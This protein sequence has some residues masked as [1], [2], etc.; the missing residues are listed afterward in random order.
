M[1]LSSIRSCMLNLV[2]L[3]F[4]KFIC[5]SSL[6]VRPKV[7]IVIMYSLSGDV[8]FISDTETL[9]L[10]WQKL[11]ID[12]L[13]DPSWPFD[14]TL[15][16]YDVKSDP[17][18]TTKYLLNR[19]H[20]KSMPNVTVIV[21]PETEIL[22]EA[23]GAV[24]AKY[25]IPCIAAV[26]NPNPTR[27][28][29]PW[30]F[31]TSFL[32]EAPASYMFQTLVDTYVSSGVRTLVAVTMH[33]EFDSYN[34][35]TCFGAAALA[36]SRGIKVQAKMSLTAESVSAD[37]VTMVEKIRDSYNPDAI[38][39]CDWASCALPENI[40]QF[41]PMPAFAKADYL[42]KALSLLDCVDQPG[43]QDY[44]QQGLY[45]YVSAGQ[46]ANEKLRGPDYTEDSTPYSSSFRPPTTANFTVSTM[47]MFYI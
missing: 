29:R 39:W 4:L 45:Q 32:I 20:N 3:V 42:P 24:A 2:A 25:G 38:M 19:I 11:L 13:R 35:D 5:T 17:D 33:Q 47:H 14:A 10:Y 41:N 37:V 8:A 43:I 30:Y 26:T 18:L 16:L 21:S 46:Y 28:S 15:E 27:P 7:N 22:G 36:A 6:Q 23:A 34:D 40:I 12:K 44:Y 9:A 31:S 1:M